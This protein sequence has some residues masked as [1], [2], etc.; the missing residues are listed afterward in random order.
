VRNSL[1]F[2]K[3]SLGATRD[4]VC[5]NGRRTSGLKMSKIWLW[6]C[7]FP[8]RFRST[9]LFDK[10]KLTQSQM[11]LLDKYCDDSLYKQQSLLQA[12]WQHHVHII[13]VVVY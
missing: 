12:I 3:K 13:V 7:V 10:S 11:F 8:N 5:H 1:K 6:H 2:E 4:N 9:R